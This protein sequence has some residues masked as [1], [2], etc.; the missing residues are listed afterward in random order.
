MRKD[1]NN[2]I[3]ILII[4]NYSR[5]NFFTL[6]IF[7]YHF[8]F[9]FFHLYNFIEEKKNDCTVIHLDYICHDAHIS[10][11]ANTFFFKSVLLLL[12]IYINY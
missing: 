11:Q 1:E 4:S 7:L 5:Q 3:S 12:S 9:F 8:L 6:I 10:Q 2:V